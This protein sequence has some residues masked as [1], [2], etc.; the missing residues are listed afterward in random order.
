MDRDQA[1]GWMARPNMSF[2]GPSP[3]QL[4]AAGDVSTIE[5]I[6]AY[7]AAEIAPD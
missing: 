5:R 4:I 1:L 7:L 2:G 3:L 6:L